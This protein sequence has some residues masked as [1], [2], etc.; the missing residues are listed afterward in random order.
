MGDRPRSFPGCAQV[1]TKVCRKDYGWSV[2]LVYDPSELPGVTTARPGVAG[3]LQMVSEPTLTVS[4]ARTGQL[5]R[6]WWRTDQG[7]GYV[8]MTRGS[9]G[10]DTVWYVCC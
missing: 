8:R 7:R 5:R 2:G 1:R 3:V 10:R 4:R 9:S 6:I